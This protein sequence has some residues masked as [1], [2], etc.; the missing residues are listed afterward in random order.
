M[1]LPSSAFSADRCPVC[2]ALNQCGLVAEA[3]V[4]GE[5]WCFQTSIAP[6][7]LDRLPAD[8]RDVACLCPRCAGLHAIDE[9]T[10]KP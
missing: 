9:P 4:A 10:R 7:A 8:E 6:A 3:R 2:G 1:P 5:C